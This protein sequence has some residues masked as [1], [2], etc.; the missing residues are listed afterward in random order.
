[1]SAMRFSH[2]MGSLV[3]AIVACSLLAACSA[4]E[5]GV[6][7]SGDG[8]VVANPLNAAVADAASSPAPASDVDPLPPDVAIEHC[9]KVAS[10][11]GHSLA[12]AVHAYPGKSRTVLA[13]VRAIAHA[14]ASYVV[15]GTT[16]TD[17]VTP[18]YV[19]DG[20]VM[21]ECGVPGALPFDRV[22]FVLPQ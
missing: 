14:S 7:S 20:A 12:V 17:Y 5:Q 21:V 1:R 11:E 6:E 15:D 3:S 22:T 10:V 19:R 4:S 13:A 2:V 8:G 9:D 18:A 16:F